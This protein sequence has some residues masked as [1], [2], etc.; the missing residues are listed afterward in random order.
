MSHF[1]LPCGNYKWLVNPSGANFPGITAVEENRPE[2][3]FYEVDFEVPVEL[4][5]SIQDFVFPCM[6]WKR[7]R[8]LALGLTTKAGTRKFNR[9]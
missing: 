2:G 3:W 7:V 8:K 5:D 6:I 1:Y 9:S 4:H